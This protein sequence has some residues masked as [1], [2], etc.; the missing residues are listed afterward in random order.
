MLDLA[1]NDVAKEDRGVTRLSLDVPAR[2]H[3]LLLGGTGSGKSTILELFAGTIRPDRGSVHMGSREVTRF[4]A[5]ARPVV[6][7]RL[8][9]PPG[10]RWSVGRALV[11]AVRRREGLDRQER[12]D[13]LG[14]Q[15]EAWDLEPLFERRLDRIS[16]S[17]RL[18]V[19]LARLLL[20]RP[21]ILLAERLFSEAL[22]SEVFALADRFYRELR[23][24]GCT[25]VTEP[26]H[27]EEIGCAD[28]VAVI[29]RGAVVASG[30]AAAIG[31]RP[32]SLAVARAFGPG[33]V[34]P[35]SLREG[36]VRSPLGEWRAEAPDGD[37]DAWV[38][39][40]AVRMARGGE[41]SD[42]IFAV[43]EARFDGRRW[44]ATG[45]ITGGVILRV[46]LESA[47]RLEKGSLLPMVLVT[48][49]ISLFPRT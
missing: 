35:V 23:V 44:L 47:S 25:V 36:V 21:A 15:L 8:T 9:A 7:S 19:R 39:P 34:L 13:E 38:H 16:G 43:E 12:S 42:F 46:E 11:S 4:R 48:E 1:L 31:R 30:E 14:L 22:E 33:T 27:G 45:F 10:E 28:R 20:L 6:H 41:E 49:A 17:E 37:H 29:D 3:T 18:R 24:H 26:A 32:P 40:A 2:S 5:G